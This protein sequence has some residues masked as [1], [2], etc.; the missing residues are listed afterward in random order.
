MF[1]NGEEYLWFLENNCENGCKRLRNGQCSIFRRLEEARFDE[2]RFPYSELLD[3]AGG[4]GGK[5]CKRFTTDPPERK[6]SNKPIDGQIT[7]F[8][9]GGNLNANE[10]GM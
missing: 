5:E 2:S 10:T 3:Y 7:M 4:Y 1:S 9:D 6:A 8:E